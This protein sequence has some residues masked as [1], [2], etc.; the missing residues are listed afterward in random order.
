MTTIQPPS[1]PREEQRPAPLDGYQA[2]DK[3]Q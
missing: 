2:T 1:D 3:Q